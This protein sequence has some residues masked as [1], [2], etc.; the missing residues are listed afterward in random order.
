MLTAIT[1]G[2]QGT[3]R[4]NLAGDLAYSSFCP[5]K[6]SEFL[7]LSLDPTAMRAVSDC[8]AVL[9]E[10]EGMARFVPNVDMYLAMYVRKEALLS[11]QIEGTQC[12][13]DDVL[14]PTNDVNAS[15]DLADV[16]NYTKAANQAINLLSSMPLC[17]RL[18][19][20]VH[21]TLLSGVR[22]SEKSPGEFRTSQ[23]WIGPTGCSLNGA[24]YVPPNVED[25]QDALNDLER[26]V[27]ERQDVDPVVKA[28]LVH[29]QFETIHPFLDGNGRMGRL[30]ILLSLMNDGALTRPVVY[31]S[32]ELKRRR[33]EYYDRL[34]AVRTRGDFEGWVAFFCEC[35]LTSARDARD[36]LSRLASLHIESEALVRERSGRATSNAL[37]LLEL[38]EGNPIVDAAF[39]TERLG[40]SKS[41]AISLVSHFVDLGILAQRE[42][43]KK[44]YRTFSYEPYLAILRSGDT[45]L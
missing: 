23:N 32:Y 5:G 34:T 44:R 40:V 28:A 8:R 15:R 18:L 39:V 10:V 26:F 17:M 29:Y 1:P 27:N 12:T 42:S 4:T 31:P 41:A 38:L 13:F 45:P 2:R 24:S 25:M 6:M 14:D 30:L 37:R 21:T 22:G 7:P 35:L 43:E 36:S 9:G 19:R 16:V 11:S 20:T 3:L 33:G